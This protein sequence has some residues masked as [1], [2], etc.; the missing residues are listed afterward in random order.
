M[1]FF[2]FQQGAD[3]ATQ[4]DFQEYLQGI[5]CSFISVLDRMFVFFFLVSVT[6]ASWDPRST[7]SHPRAK[8]FS[9]HTE[10]RYH[11]LFIGSSLMGK[12]SDLTLADMLVYQV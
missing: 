7:K 4:A 5:F 12:G 8:K 6:R 11:H 2:G 1:S 3:F 9:L 10:N